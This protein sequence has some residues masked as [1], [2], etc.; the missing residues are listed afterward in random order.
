MSYSVAC[1]N[2]VWSSV[3]DVQSAI[4]TDTSFSLSFEGASSFNFRSLS[5]CANSAMQTPVVMCM[6]HDIVL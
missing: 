1:A 6:Q 2:L 3:G 5:L 4:V